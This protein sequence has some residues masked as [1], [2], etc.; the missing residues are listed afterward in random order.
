MSEQNNDRIITRNTFFEE[1]LGIITLSVAFLK[2]YLP[3]KIQ[4]KLNFEKLNFEKIQFRSGGAFG[5]SQP[6]I[7]YRVPTLKEDHVVHIHVIIEY[8]S[9][10]DQGTIFQL[11]DYVNQLCSEEVRAN[12]IDPKTKKRK[13]WTQQFLLSPVIPIILYYGEKPFTGKTEYADLINVKGIEEIRT[14]Q[15]RLR[16][17]LVDL[18]FIADAQLPRNPDAPKLYVILQIMKIIFSKIR[19]ML[20]KRFCEI[21]DELKPYSQISKYRRLIREIWRYLVRNT[22]KIIKADYEEIEIIVRDA[23]GN[24]NM[25]TLV[26]RWES[27]GEV[28]TILRLLAWRFGTIPKLIEEQLSEMTDIERLDQL[29]EIAY[30]CQTPEEFQNRLNYRLRKQ[31]GCLPRATD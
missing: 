23:I 2:S 27:R 7:V 10:D 13:K 8:N 17:I 3:R 26:Q 16:A 9:F 22:E 20:K 31:A 18:T 25:P 12:L 1:T 4:R 11:H 6:D 28:K 14:Y 30:Y 19:T 24:D 21:L 15:P 5:E 29:L